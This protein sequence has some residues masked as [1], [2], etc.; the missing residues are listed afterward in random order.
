ML[1]TKIAIVVNNCARY[2]W[3]VIGVAAVLMLV[4]AAYT[5][6]N[7]AINTDINKLISPDLPWRQREIAFERAYPQHLRSILAV[8]DAPTQ[9]LAS[10]AAAAL[11][12]RLEAD[13][14]HFVQVTQPGGG[15][16]FRRNGLLFLPV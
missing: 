4:T 9:E 3:A 5:A 1:K 11:V 13:K 6:Q 16:F 15:E 14:T 7:F 8:V 10:E 12:K 2:A